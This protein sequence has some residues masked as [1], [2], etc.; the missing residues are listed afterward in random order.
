MNPLTNISYIRELAEE[1]GFRMTKQL[2]Q[3]FLINPEIPYKTAAA[4]CIDKET[5]VIEIGPGIGTLTYELCKAAKKVV[6]IELDSRLIPVLEHTMKDFDNLTFINAD[7]LKTDFG[8]IIKDEFNGGKTVVCANLP[9]YITTPVIMY[10]L[11][12]RFGFER[13][14]VMIQKEVADRFCAAPATAE[15][16]AVTVSSAYYAQT[17][18]HFN[19]SP[20]SFYPAPK[21]TSTV[22]SF[23]IRKEPPVTVKNEFFF[24]E[25][26]KNSFIQRRKIL[27]NSVSNTMSPRIEKSAVIKAL[28]TLGL[29]ENVRGEALGIE[30]FADLSNLLAK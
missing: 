8:Q 14:T 4:A 21:V 25:L 20:G 27:C 29:P 28:S 24:F 30:E 15:Y 26:I 7:A 5:N 22:M 19:V 10:L 12:S 23:I 6:S 1:Y 17:E 11:E 9:Y 13:I 18:K 16:G 2:G 3:N